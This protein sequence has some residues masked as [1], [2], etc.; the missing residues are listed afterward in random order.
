MIKQLIRIFQRYSRLVGRI[1]KSK[2]RHYKICAISE[3]EIESKY[4]DQTWRGK[5]TA[6]TRGKQP[7][8]ITEYAECYYREKDRS[9]SLQSSSLS[10]PRHQWNNS[11]AA[12]KNRAFLCPYLSFPMQT[13]CK[14]L[15][16]LPIPRRACERNLFSPVY[17]HMI[18][19]Y[20]A[21]QNWNWHMTSCHVRENVYFRTLNYFTF[22]EVDSR[23]HT[24]LKSWELHIPSLET[25]CPEKNCCSTANIFIKLVVMLCLSRL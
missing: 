25:H 2:H 5:S 16:K 17:S 8:F 1:G 22:S 24:T 21:N 13:F 23:T 12:A 7:T 20:S 4:S 6:L 10:F 19:K 15:P 14:F 3:H 18:T 9:F 11:F